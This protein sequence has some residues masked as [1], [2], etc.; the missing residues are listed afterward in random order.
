M[1]GN[2]TGERGGKVYE[3]RKQRKGKLVEAMNEV[4]RWNEI[5]GEGEVKGCQWKG[6]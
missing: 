5:R 6:R 1:D 3:G 2:E 4:S